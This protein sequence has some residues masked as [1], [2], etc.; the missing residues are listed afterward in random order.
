MLKQLYISA[1]MSGDPQRNPDICVFD[2]PYPRT[3]L[4]SYTLT[5]HDISLGCNHSNLSMISARR[6]SSALA[7]FKQVAI[8]GVRLWLSIKLIAG[9]VRPV[10]SARASWDRP[11]DFRTRASSSTIFKTNCSE[12]SSLIRIIIPNLPKLL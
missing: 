9:R 3:N 5:V 11:S 12:T 7:I 1:I 10:F 6:T 8:V 4:W 2:R